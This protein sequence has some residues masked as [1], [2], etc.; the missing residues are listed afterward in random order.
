MSVLADVAA[1]LE[2]IPAMYGPCSGSPIGVGNAIPVGKGFDGVVAIGKVIGADGLLHGWIYRT[3]DNHLMIQRITPAL[4]RDTKNFA[5]T[6]QGPIGP[7]SPTHGDTIVACTT[8]DYH[9]PRAI[10]L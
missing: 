3:E 5:T 10:K 7:F 2:R 9:F 4:P 1:V 6:Q 8:K